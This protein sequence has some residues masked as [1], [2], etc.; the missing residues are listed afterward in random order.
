MYQHLFKCRVLPLSRDL[1][2]LYPI[3]C[4]CPVLCLSH[5]SVSLLAS[6]LHSHSPT[7]SSPLHPRPSLS[8]SSP[9]S[10]G[11]S[12][13]IWAFQV[14]GDNTDPASLAVPLPGGCSRK[15]GQ[16]AEDGGRRSQT[17]NCSLAL[18]GKE[19]R[20]QGTRNRGCGCQIGQRLPSSCNSEPL[21]AL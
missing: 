5:S 9:G 1:S 16:R 20:K 19:T 6:L 2:L 7:F 13:G 18:I 17:C 10:M 15:G 11:P 4:P 3:C 8:V 21:P 14:P 12:P